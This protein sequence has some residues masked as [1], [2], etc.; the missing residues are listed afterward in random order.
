MAGLEFQAQ[1]DAVELGHHDIKKQHIRTSRFGGQQDIARV[2]EGQGFKAAVLE[3][4]P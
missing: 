2:N 1:I 4:R 3:Y